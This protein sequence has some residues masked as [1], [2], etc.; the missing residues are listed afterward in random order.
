MGSPYNAALPG[1]GWISLVPTG[2]T[3]PTPIHLA[4][5]EDGDYEIKQETSDVEDSDG[6]VID[7]F[8]TKE[9]ITGKLSLKDY[10]NSLVAAVARGVTISTGSVV[11]TSHQAIVP[12]TPFQITVT[13]G[14]TFSADL[15][16]IN[17]TDKKPM[18]RDAT[19]TGTGVYAVNT[20]TGVYTFHTADAA[21]EMLI[22]YRYTATAGTTAEIAKAVSGSAAPRFQIHVYK[23]SVP[24]KEWGFFV[25][26]AQIPGLSVSFK[27]KDW[28][29][30]SLNWKALLSDT[31]KKFYTY[32][33]G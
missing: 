25:P 27:K 13:Q 7:S 30:V 19:A 23:S 17:L 20:T 21:D 31:N 24:G 14:A 29:A 32:G 33:P 6:N 5:V 1:M 2:V 10:S 16:V 22:M 9:D 4:L 8:V 26:N 11:G 28:S 18:K 3:N 12:T 15:G